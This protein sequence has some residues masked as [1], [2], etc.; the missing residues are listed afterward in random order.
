[1]QFLTNAPLSL[2]FKEMRV[3]DCFEIE[4]WVT[5]LG[6]WPCLCPRALPDVKST[7]YRKYRVCMGPTGSQV[8]GKCTEGGCRQQGSAAVPSQGPTSG[9]E[10]GP[11]ATMRKAPD[12]G[13]FLGWQAAWGVF[14]LTGAQRPWVSGERFSPCSGG[15]KV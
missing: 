9:E 11:E 15:D 5:G 1:M 2:L 7:I 3:Y 12:V 8:G 13:R 6:K 4:L 14:L 10:R